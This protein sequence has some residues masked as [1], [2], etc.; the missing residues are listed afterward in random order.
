[1]ADS[2]LKK[3]YNLFGAAVP[4]FS[5]PP[6]GQPLSHVVRIVCIVCNEC[7]LEENAVAGLL[8]LMLLL[9][10]SLLLGSLPLLPE[11]HHAWA[12]RSPY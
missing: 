3:S 5:S 10:V 9:K 4:E 7:S 12:T 6:Q 11:C 2:D 8:L 1:M